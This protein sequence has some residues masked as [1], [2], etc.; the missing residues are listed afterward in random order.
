MSNYI[1]KSDIPW[2]GVLAFTRGQIVP[3]EAVETH[4]L[5]D[6]VVGENTKEGRQLKADVSGQ[7]LSTFE[8][9][10]GTTSTS[11]AAGKSTTTQEG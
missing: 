10:S 6:Y 1:A 3:A 9:S 8:A 7:P 2:G 4:G 11:R 5:Q